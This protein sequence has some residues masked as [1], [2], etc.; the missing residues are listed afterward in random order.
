[1]YG[2]FS[3]PAVPTWFATRSGEDIVI[4][5]VEGLGSLPLEGLDHGW[6]LCWYGKSSFFFGA[7][8][9]AA[10]TV[11]GWDGVRIW[12]SSVYPADCPFLV[13]F[14]EAPASLKAEKMGGLSVDPGSGI[15]R[16]LILPLLGELMPK[17]DETEKWSAGLPKDIVERCDWW[18]AHVDR[19]PEHVQ[20]TYAFDPQTDTITLSEKFTLEAF[21]KGNRTAAPLPPAV[22]T[23]YLTGFPAIFSKKPEDPQ[24]FTAVGDYLAVPD[25]DRTR[26]ASRASES[27]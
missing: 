14:S 20:E 23:A 19:I 12:N 21:R 7:T 10:E 22:A 16:V 3:G 4:Q 1:V 13:L 5:D 27:T 2:G 11:Y 15:C 26:S 6:L 25:V 18:A 17:T 24:L 8:R 9:S